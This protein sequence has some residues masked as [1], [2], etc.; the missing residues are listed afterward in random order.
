[1]PLASDRVEWDTVAYDFSQRTVSLT[2]LRGFFQQKAGAYMEN[3]IEV[4]L[5]IPQDDTINGIVDTL[6]TPT[7]T[8]WY[9][10]L[11]FYNG[12][13]TWTG[14]WSAFPSNRY[15]LYGNSYASGM[16]FDSLDT[17]ISVPSGVNMDDLEL[18]VV[19][20]SGINEAAFAEA[21]LAESDDR[22]SQ[23]QLSINVYPN[24]ASPLNDIQLTVASPQDNSLVIRLFH[25]DGTTHSTLYNG[26][27]SAGLLH[28]TTIPASTLNVG[29]Y[30]ATFHVGNEAYVKR[31][32]VQ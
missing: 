24:P 8:L 11:H 17:Q 25:G 10:K 3:Y 31:F 29:T 7:K 1:M 28:T 12:T 22:E 15:T 6:V 19:M 4:V 13:P 16:T 2:N 9:G 18:L 20:H 21:Q 23:D 27:I 14:D 32:I 5:W 26:T 30:F